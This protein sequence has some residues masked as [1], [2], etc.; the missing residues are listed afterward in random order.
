MSTDARFQQRALRDYLELMEEMILFWKRL[1]PECEDTEDSHTWFNGVVKPSD[2]KSADCIAAWND[3]MREVLNKKKVK[4]AKAVERVINEPATVFHACSYKDVDAIYD[5]SEYTVFR[6][7]KLRERHPTLSEDD[8]ATLWKYIDH[9]NRSAY[10]YAGR[11]VPRIPTKEEIQASISQKK[12]KPVGGEQASMAKAFQTALDVLVKETGAEIEDEAQV[13]IAARWAKTIKM[14]TAGGGTVSQ[15]CQAQDPA[16]MDYLAREIPELRLETLDL[17]TSDT[18]ETIKQ[19]NSFST[20]NEQIPT[21]MMSRIEDY[22]SKLAD[23]LVSGRKTMGNVDLSAIGQEVLAQCD[24]DDMNKFA[25]NINELLPA[26]SN[27]Q[28][29]GLFNQAQ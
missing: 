6:K 16:A 12:N 25:S 17:I 15:L 5:S 28:A 24:P 10:E 18:W 29:S 3:C 4:Y 13:D 8:R 2:K 23:D 22:A 21:K 26:L 27:F 20:V 1:F 9:M 14:E 19:L 7:L 11:P